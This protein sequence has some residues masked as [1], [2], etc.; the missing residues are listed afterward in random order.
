MLF[1]DSLA[2]HRLYVRCLLHGQHR[3][4]CSMRLLGLYKRYMP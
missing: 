1:V 2:A 4:S 3:C